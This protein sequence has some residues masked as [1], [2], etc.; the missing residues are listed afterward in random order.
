MLISE[1]LKYVLL[2][3]FVSLSIIPASMAQAQE[4]SA[5]DLVFVTED[6][7]PFNYE[8]DGVVQ[9]ISVDLL[10]KTME[11]MDVD[12]NKSEIQILPWIE[13]YRRAFA[14]KNVVIFSTVPLPGRVSSFKWAGPIIPIKDV[15]LA[16]KDE[17]IVITNPEDIGS[18][19]IGV[20]N[21][22]APMDALLKLGVAPVNLVVEEGSKPLVEMMENGTLDLLAYE[23]IGGMRLIEK[24]GYDS[25][26]Y[27]TVYVLGKYELYYAFNKET[28]DSLVRAF[29]A[30]LND[31]KVV[32]GD[33]TSQYQRILYNYL[34]IRHAESN[35]SNEN[36]IELVEMTAMDIAKDAGGTLDN[37]NAG[38]SPYKDEERADLYVFV[39]DTNVTLIADAGSPYLAGQSMKGRGDVSGKMFRDEIVAGALE[40]GS[41]FVDYIFTDPT[42][43][44]LY[45]KATYYMLVV[46]SDGQEYVVCS[47]RYE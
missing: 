24:A 27:E 4:L 5:G 45:H 36:V 31:T 13:G 34:P 14:E 12:L 7:P 18:Y 39:Y 44:G 41:G 15:L 17:D 25:D 32:G 26:N 42:M 1:W 3:F 11:G 19:R 16:E 20:V 6:L 29:Q 23:E 10:E 30:A 38:D 35:V 33:G 8:E 2:I 21:G 22:T 37:I 46:G 9:G 40:K 43:S 47:G 28:P